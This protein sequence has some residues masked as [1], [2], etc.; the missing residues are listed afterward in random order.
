MKSLFRNYNINVS[1]AYVIYLPNN[2]ISVDLSQ[3]CLD[4]C[5]RVNQKVSLWEAFD[6]TG[7]E[8]VVP[9]HIKD[10]GWYKWLKTTDHEQSIA[11][12]ATSLSHI[13]LWVKCMEEDT[14]LIVLE[15]DAIMIKSFTKHLNP[16]S[17]IYLGCKDQ[18]QG[19][20]NPM[21]LPMSSINKNWYFMNRA[22]A[23]S[24]DPIIAKN[25]FTN[26]LSRGIFESLD[27]MIK[28]E[29]VSITQVGL[30][31]YDEPGETTIKIRKV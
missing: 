18:M 29:D 10:Q 19:G 6:G 27:V 12:I 28:S 11:E 26:V 25:L 23:Y 3:R 21:I 8:I 2:K 7:D 17:V 22:H 14:P 16:N 31:A 1:Q 4:S 15:H 5:N 24:I 13:S 30:Y 20:Y 9:N